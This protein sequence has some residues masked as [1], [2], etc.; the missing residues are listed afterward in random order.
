MNDQPNNVLTASRMGTLLRCPR[1]HY[2]QYEIGLRKDTTGKALRFGSA[3][4]RAMEARWKGSNYE[5]ALALAIPEGVDLDAYA[6]ATLAG[7]LAGYY[8]F[9]GDAETFGRLNPEIQFKMSIVGSK[10]FTA[11][12]KIDGLGSMT[13]GRS[14]LIES[15]T[16]GDSI[17]PASNFWMRLRF[18]AQVYQYLLAAKANGWDIS[19]VLYDVTRKPCIK[20]K[21]VYDRDADGKKIVLDVDNKRVFK[22]GGKP[23]ET[24][25]EEQGWKVKE[26]VETPEEYGKR[27]AADC[28]ARPEFYFVRKEVAIFADDLETFKIQRLALGRMILMFRDFQYSVKIHADAWPRAVSEQNCKFCAYQSFCLLNVEVDPNSPPEGFSVKPFNPELEQVSDP[29]VEEQ[30]TTE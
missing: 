10:T 16:T 17:A 4:H 11:E 27:L 5:E 3:W 28:H 8:N 12:G 6:C 18:N 26:H 1:A 21:A 7:L 24:G 25:D 14:G 22:K 23:R 20:P 2:W 19:E 29:T 15:K 13:D 9:Y 30:E